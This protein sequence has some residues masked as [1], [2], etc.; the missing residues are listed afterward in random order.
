M[1]VPQTPTAPNQQLQVCNQAEF[2]PTGKFWKPPSVDARR[3]LHTL[4]LVWTQPMPASCAR[5]PRPCW[6]NVQEIWRAQARNE[7]P[8]HKDTPIRARR[9]AA[10]VLVTFWMERVGVV[11]LH[12]SPARTLRAQEWLKTVK[13]EASRKKSWNFCGAGASEA[14]ENVKK[15]QC[16]THQEK[17]RSL[18]ACLL[19]AEP[20]GAASATTAAAVVNGGC[21]FAHQ[22]R[23]SDPSS[24]VCALQRRRG[25][26]ISSPSA[27]HPSLPRGEAHQSTKRPN[28]GS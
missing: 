20:G 21:F 12:L 17:Q 22:K 6:H 13:S 15:R 9:S 1:P 16:G 26:C 23:R 14:R 25:G 19:L 7:W 2:L 8:S 10:L 4:P 28:V 5:A 24:R 3:R 18:G 11:R 27:G